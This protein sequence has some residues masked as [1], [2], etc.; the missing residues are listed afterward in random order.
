M[1]MWNVAKTPNDEAWLVSAPRA[2]E[3]NVSLCQPASHTRATRA[4]RREI[5]AAV[6]IFPVW[7]VTSCEG[8]V[9]HLL[10]AF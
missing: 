4:W 10:S 5:I 7:A 8:P 9:P 2:R 6:A 1:R 3:R